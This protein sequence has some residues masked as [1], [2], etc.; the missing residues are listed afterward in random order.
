MSDANVVSIEQEEKIIEFGRKN[1][2]GLP[3]VVLSLAS[4]GVV[5]GDIGTS[6]LYVLPAIFGELHHQPTENFILGVFSTIFWTITLMVLVKYVW[7]TLAVDDHGEGG[8][9]ALYSII[10]R[11][12]TSKSSDFGVDIQEE[13]ITSKTRVFL[14]KNKWLRKVIMGIVITCASLSMADGILTPAISVISAAEG[15]QFHTGISHDT[16]IFITIGILV[17]LFSIQFLGTGKVGV[18]FGPAMLVWFAFN[19]S[20]GVYNVTK[21][22][23]VFRA[24]SPHYMYYFWGE[25]GSWE[26]FK[27][28]GEV[29]LAI[30]GVEALYADMGHL[31]A[32][33]I[34]ISFS[35]IVYPSLVMNYLGQT[36]V[37]LLDYNTSSS[38]Y[39]SSIPA[40]LAWPSLV[41]AASAAIIA[42]QALITG[43]FTVVQQAMHANV[44]PRVAIFQTNKKHAGQIY[45]PVVNYAL[46]VGSITVV[47]IFQAS[48]K[49][50]SAY[51]FAVSIVVVLT[52]ILFCVVLHLQDRDKLFSF[53]FSSFFGIISIAFAASLTIKIPKGAWFSAAIGSV[54][55]FVS[56]VWHRGHRMKMR[57]IKNNRLSARQVFSKP[58]NNSKN[59]VF[60]NELTDGIVPAYNQL[61][62]LITISGTNNIVLS[63]RKMSIPR[64]HED[65]RFLITGYDGMYHVIARYGYAEIIDHGDCFARKLCEAVNAESSDV[66]F[67]MGR[68]KLLTTNTSFY[69][70]IVIAMYSAMVKL[71]SWTTDTFNTPTSKLIIFEASYEI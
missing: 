15:I 12:I 20:V 2:R 27:L 57:Y 4:L 63:V 46:L 19:F 5:F 58:T 45:I 14:E 36:V 9:F 52:H 41:I 39:W 54:L 28:L 64:V 30:T 43:T 69:N 29:F 21:M 11:A 18:I 24:L 1:V 65:Q 55:V 53:V 31:N 44:F 48:S 37:V 50:V 16:V 33:S 22:P 51:G 23:G 68:T 62:N 71:S 26:A 66:V 42:S 35:T 56:F 67:V 61:E 3:L 40:K 32:M 59:I 25:F 6:P 7:F 13:K 8:V 49:I 10:R 70:K 60:Y 47:L 34:R 38:L 17:G